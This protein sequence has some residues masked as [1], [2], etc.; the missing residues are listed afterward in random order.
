LAPR[1]I[2]FVL[3]FFGGPAVFAYTRHKIPAIPTVWGWMSWCLYILLNDPNFDRSHLWGA[4]RFWHYAPSIFG[5]W[6]F[7]V[8]IG[9][10]LILK[11]APGLFLGLPR[12]RPRLWAALMLLYP[13]FSVYPQGIIFRAFLFTRYREV[14]VTDWALVIASAAAFAFV[15]IVFHNRLALI[16]TA[17]GGFLFGMRYLQ[18][19]SLFI[20][21][22]EH[23]LYGCALFTLGVGRSLH[24]ASMREARA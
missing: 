24:H 23:S 1:A 7:A 3:L 15:H 8:M 11:Y 12:T 17:L 19:G 4:A 6:A 20:T 5:L 21:C 10:V 2:E 16:V 22:I 13:V 18:T 14:F 9:I